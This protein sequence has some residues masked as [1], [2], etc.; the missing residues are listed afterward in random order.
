[1]IIDGRKIRDGRKADLIRRIKES[2]RKPNLVIISV[3]NRPDSETYIN[4]KI[5]YGESLGV[6]VKRVSFD[7][8]VKQSEIL[9]SIEKLNVDPDV[10]GVIC[11]LPLPESIDRDAVLDSIVPSK[12]VDCLSHLNIARV[13]RGNIDFLPATTRGIMTILES[14]KIDV[15]TKKVLVIGRSNLVGKPTAMALLA[16]D[17]TVSV[18]HSKTPNLAEYTKAADVIISATGIKNLINK[19]M[20]NPNQV[21]IDVGINKD[22]ED[23]LHGDVAFDEVSKIVSAITPVPGGVGPMT[24]QSI[25]EN[26]MDLAEGKLNLK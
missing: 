3:G 2:S 20:V 24:V 16:K 23:I 4:A 12:D 21:I 9:E 13:F 1:M 11:Q 22:G 6:S 5:N 26:L 8:S 25:F 15:S 19:D 7:M 10:D 18:A 14:Q 17:A